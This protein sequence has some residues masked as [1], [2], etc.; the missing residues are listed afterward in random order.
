M[1]LFS[2]AAI[3]QRKITM[4]NKKLLISASLIASIASASAFARTE[5]HYVG[6]SVINT[7]SET[8]FDQ[9]TH[10]NDKYSFG[11]DYKYAFNCEKFFLAP[12]VFYDHNALTEEVTLTSGA[13][14]ASNTKYSYGVKLLIGYDVT[15]KFAPFAIVG[16]SQTRGDGSSYGP[17]F[18]F[19]KETSTD[20][21]MVYGLGFKY[22]LN[23][24]VDLNAS[25]ELTQFGLSNNLDGIVGGSDKL[26]STYK[27]ARIGASYRF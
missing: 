15:D 23:D 3:N 16:H 6:A 25:Y 22:S 20:E 8:S 13:K 11:V 5:G 9:D 17:G 14:I 21:G 7:S 4:I 19:T 2:G 12:G 18:V 24:K 26:N 1:R 27:V 10:R